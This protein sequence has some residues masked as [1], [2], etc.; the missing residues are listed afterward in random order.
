VVTSF[1]FRVHRVPSTVA[2]F[3]LRWP[4]S[5]G[6]NALA[7]WQAWAPHAR[8]ELTSIFHLNG[9]GAEPAQVTGQYFGPSRDLAGLLA[10]LM[11]SGPTTVHAGD[12]GYLSAQLMWAGCSNISFAACHTTGTQP[13]GT[14]PRES[15]QA[16][17]D[18]VAK[19]LPAA[20]RNALVEAAQARAQIPGSGAVLFDSYGGAI[21][22]FAP[23]ATA[24]VHRR[25]LFCIQYLTYNG[26]GDWLGSVHATMRPYVTGGA[27]FNYTDPGL[28]NWQ[29]AY[30]GSNYQRLL[31]I[32]R[33]IDPHHYFNFPQAIGR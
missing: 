19:P 15:F 32:R 22:Q 25:V 6:A 2:W 11:A 9:G 18:Y 1:T 3:I 23:A 33:A 5:R 27:Y 4:T 7:A 24:F 30:Y 8:G 26:G 10:P 12:L 28:R 31:R 21:N 16:K 20:A 29:T 13:G 14:L 17:S